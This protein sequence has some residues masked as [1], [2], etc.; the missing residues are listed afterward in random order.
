MTRIVE[1]AMKF[2]EQSKKEKLS[3]SKEDDKKES[4]EPD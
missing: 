2:V 3:V 4:Q 1:D